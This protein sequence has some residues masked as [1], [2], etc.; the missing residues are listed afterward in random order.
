MRSEVS[1]VPDPDAQVVVVNAV[2]GTKS[3]QNS[4]WPLPGHSAQSILVGPQPDG[5]ALEPQAGLA[6]LVTAG[7]P[8]LDAALSDL[9]L[10]QSLNLD[11]LTGISFTKG[12]YPGQEVL[13]RLHN[14]GRVKRR[15]LRFGFEEDSPPEV[16]ARINNDEAQPRGQ[17]VC[18]SS[19]ELLASV[20]LRE[21]GKALFI[22]GTNTPLTELPLPYGIPELEDA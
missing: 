10:G 14:L 6:A 2:N 8:W 9:F 13:A 5:A 15:L 1:F 11:L 19:A 3:P 17:V 4:Q 12:C 16:G 18:S 20:E 21:V 7:V 22:A